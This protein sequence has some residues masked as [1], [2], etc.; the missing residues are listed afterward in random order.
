MSIL[1][2]Q[3][4]KNSN[5]LLGE[6]S[7]INDID[8]EQGVHSKEGIVGATVN[9]VYRQR[10][11]ECL[12][13]TNS[14]LSQLG[15]YNRQCYFFLSLGGFLA[16][17]LTEITFSENTI[18]SAT[19]VLNLVSTILVILTGGCFIYAGYLEFVRKTT[20]DRIKEEQNKK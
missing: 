20:I 16:G 19:A 9:P 10:N 15:S 8:L 17:I 18:G 4:K 13:L 11:I 7:G 12:I 2:D 1:S 14:E 6:I 3:N 5:E